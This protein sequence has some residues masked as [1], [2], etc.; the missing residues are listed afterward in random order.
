MTEVRD[1]R[2]VDHDAWRA[3]FRDYGVFYETQFSEH[4]IDGVWAWL[5]DAESDVCAVVAT[6]S[7]PRQFR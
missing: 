2:E 6:R 7:V 4:V 1:I 5:M 3:L